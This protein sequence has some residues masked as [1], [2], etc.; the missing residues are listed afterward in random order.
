MQP[1]S[2]TQACDI[3][4][5]FKWLLNGRQVLIL[6]L[7]YCKMLHL[8]AVSKVGC[9]C[10]AAPGVRGSSSWSSCSRKADSTPSSISSAVTADIYSKNVEMQMKGSKHKHRY[11]G[12]T[13]AEN[14]KIEPFPEQQG[15]KMRI[16]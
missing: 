13:D 4:A 5:N 2:V 6:L 14:L 7:G 12:N 3:P 10:Q 11:F 9:D 15:K 16:I 8:W 1:E